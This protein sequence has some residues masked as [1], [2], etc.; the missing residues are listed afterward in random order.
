MLVLFRF[1]SSYQVILSSFCFHSFLNFYFNLTP[2][3]ITVNVTKFNTKR[4][5]E[6]IKVRAKKAAQVNYRFHLRTSHA[7][8]LLQALH[9]QPMTEWV[10]LNEID[11]LERNYNCRHAKT[12]KCFDASKLL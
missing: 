9:S 6:G 1:L 5:G 4:I 11:L 12:F 10:Y 3:I 8:V 7:S 2:E